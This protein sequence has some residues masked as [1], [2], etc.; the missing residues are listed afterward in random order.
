MFWG[1]SVSKVQLLAR[2]SLCV[3]VNKRQMTGELYGSD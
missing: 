2:T 3:A 1:N